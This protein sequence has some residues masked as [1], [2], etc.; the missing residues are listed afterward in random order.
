MLL[1]LPCVLTVAKHIFLITQESLWWG[2]QQPLSLIWWPCTHC[3]ACA[4]LWFLLARNGVTNKKKHRPEPMSN[5]HLLWKCSPSRPHCRTCHPTHKPS[6]SH[7][8]RTLLCS[9]QGFT[10]PEEAKLWELLN[11]TCWTS[12]PRDLRT[13]PLNPMVSI[14]VTH[15][16]SLSQA[17]SKSMQFTTR[18]CASGFQHPSSHLSHLASVYSSCSWDSAFKGAF[19]DLTSSWEVLLFWP[20]CPPLLLFL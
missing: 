1:L 12:T 16:L 17:T 9:P 2:G 15:F 10:F 20:F 18:P 11:P 13:W 14:F 4:V 3:R 7:S 5:L 6:G 19:A 8:C